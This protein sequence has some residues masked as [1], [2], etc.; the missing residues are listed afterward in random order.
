M[1]GK[2]LIMLHKVMLESYTEYGKTKAFYE[3]K[4]EELPPDGDTDDAKRYRKN[5]RE[6]DEKQNICAGVLNSI[7][8]MHLEM[9]L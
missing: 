2:E 6:L 5:V 3:E 9:K 7:E 1:T 4:L 8:M